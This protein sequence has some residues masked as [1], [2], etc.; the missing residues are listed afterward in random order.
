MTTKKVIQNLKDE[1]SLNPPCQWAELQQRISAGDLGSAAN[2]PA[3]AKRTPYLRYGSLAAV[4]LLVL[5]GVVYWQQS[6]GEFP[7]NALVPESS[8]TRTTQD[9]ASESEAELQNDMAIILPW[10][11]LSIT[12]KFSSVI[13]Q[14]V[15]YTTSSKEAIESDN[16]GARLWKG[17]VTGYDNSQMESVPHQIDAEIYRIRKVTTDFAVAVKFDGT[18]EYYPYL[19]A[20]YAPKDLQGFLADL[21]L[22][23][24]LVLHNRLERQYAEGEQLI[25]A[26]YTLPDIDIIWEML[27]SRGD[28]KNVQEEL[29]SGEQLLSCAIDIKILGRRNIAISVTE[30]GYVLINAYTAALFCIGED[31]VNAFVDYVLQNGS[32]TILARHDIGNDA[33]DSPPEQSQ[34]AF[35]GTTAAPAFSPGDVPVTVTAPM[36]SQGNTP[37]VPPGDTL[38]TAVSVME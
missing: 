18:Q 31:K 8:G 38:A 2:P 3:A 35:P 32:E 12:E 9:G 26:E 5:L 24:N 30:K 20:D 11:Q 14:N 22:R 37:A 10:H 16:I 23:E 27:L 28:A 15:D 13:Y 33:E 7:A 34:G 6:D 1:A 36:V 25:S 17:K 4:L 29:D 19:S 21:N